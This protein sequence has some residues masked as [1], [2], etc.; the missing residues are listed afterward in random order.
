[1][2]P[3]VI[4]TGIIGLGHIGKT[5]IAAL[6]NNPNFE[7]IAACDLDKSLFKIVSQRCK[8]FRDF[9]EMIRLITLDV[10]IVATPNSTHNSISREVLALGV[11][12]I[13]EKPAAYNLTDLENLLKVGKN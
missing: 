3:K 7:I 6:N 11:N 5:H 10:V 12:V 9:R 1:M 8:F 13:I 2:T 4:K